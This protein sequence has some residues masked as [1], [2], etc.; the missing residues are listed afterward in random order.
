MGKWLGWRLH[1]GK[2]GWA[3]DYIWISLVGLK[4]T[5]WKSLMGKSSWVGNR[6]WVSL[7]GLEIAHG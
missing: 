3:E 1:L 2:F 6:T 7:V 5:F 4:T